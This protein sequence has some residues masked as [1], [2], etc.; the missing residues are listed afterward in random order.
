M[1]G[2]AQT[3]GRK[4]RGALGQA[5]GVPQDKNTWQRSK[6]GRP[7]RNETW[8]SP[9]KSRQSEVANNVVTEFEGGGGKMNLA[10]MIARFTHCVRMT[11]LLRKTCNRKCLRFHMLRFLCSYR[12][13]VRDFLIP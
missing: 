2:T 8:G 7:P 13:C 6:T 11:E 3:G 5:D 9:T 4:F 12:S 10:H 1:R